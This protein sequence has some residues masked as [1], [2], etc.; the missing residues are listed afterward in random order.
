MHPQTKTPLMGR[1]VPLLGFFVQCMCAAGW[2]EFLQLETI[3]ELLFIF[4]RKMVD[5]LALLTLQ[6]DH[7]FLCHTKNVRMFLLVQRLYRI[8]INMSIPLYGEGF[9]IDFSLYYAILYILL[10][11][12]NL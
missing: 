1:S 7:L 5:C 12:S 2:T 8:E 3:L 9:C 11:K 6:L 10:L 4:S